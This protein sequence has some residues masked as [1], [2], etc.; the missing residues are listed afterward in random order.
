MTK[1]GLVS[2]QYET[3]RGVWSSA[4]FG[5]ADAPL[6]HSPPIVLRVASG[7]EAEFAIATP[8][9]AGTIPGGKGS[10]NRVG[11]AFFTRNVSDIKS[12]SYA[13]I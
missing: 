6:Q 13:I 12:V 11:T 4:E 9:L 10:S 7:R 2:A 1:R 5:A 3:R 8:G